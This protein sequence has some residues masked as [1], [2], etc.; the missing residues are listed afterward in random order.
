MFK[1]H[2]RRNSREIHGCRR[3]S[4]KTMRFPPSPL[5]E[6]QIPC[7][8][9][10][11][12]LRSPSNTTG[13]LTSFKQLRFPKHT[14]TSL[15]GHQ[16]QQS[17]SRKAPCTPNHL[18]MRATSHSSIGEES[19]F[20]THTRSTALSQLLKLEKIPKV[21]AVSRKDFVFPLSST[22]GLVPLKRLEWN[23]EFPLTNTKG[24]LNPL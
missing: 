20:S 22:E 19:Q 9:S 5:D 16:G 15:D 23:S 17:N 8:G 11:A 6:A 3:N 13:G 1:E 24:G 10:R 14:V 21:P 4:R 18:E 2:L 12:I 7:M